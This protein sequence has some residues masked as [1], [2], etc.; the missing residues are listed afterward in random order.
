MP[1]W[2]CHI[3]AWPALAWPPDH[4]SRAACRALLTHLGGPEDNAV[5]IIVGAVVGSLVGSILL[6]AACFCVYAA[7]KK[8][9]SGAS[10]RKTSGARVS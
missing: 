4:T 2:Q 8:R 1:S 3:Q 10:Q 5:G 7:S 6:V 9:R